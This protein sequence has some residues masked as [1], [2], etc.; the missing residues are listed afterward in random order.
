[1]N[2]LGKSKTD[3]N[4]NLSKLTAKNLE[5]ARRTVQATQFRSFAQKASFDATAQLGRMVQLVTKKD[6]FKKR[7]EN[8]T[9]SNTRKPPNG[10]KS[11]IISENMP[12][13][14]IRS[15]KDVELSRNAAEET[16]M[17]GKVTNGS[18]HARFNIYKKGSLKKLM[19]SSNSTLYKSYEPNP[20][21]SMK[22]LSQLTSRKLEAK[23]TQVPIVGNI[24]QGN[25][26]PRSKRK[27]F[28]SMI[29]QP[30]KQSSKLID[31][32]ELSA[33]KE[34][35][36]EV[37]E[38]D[39]VLRPGTL[40]NKTVSGA[41]MKS[42]EH[43]STSRNLLGKES[44]HNRSPSKNSSPVSAQN[45]N[46]FR[47]VIMKNTGKVAISLARI[48]ASLGQHAC[49]IGEAKEPTR[50]GAWNGKKLLDHGYEA[51]DINR[52]KKMMVSVDRLKDRVEVVGYSTYRNRSN[53]TF[54]DVL[55]PRARLVTNRQ[56]DNPRS[57]SNQAS[58]N[59]ETNRSLSKTG[60][61]DLKLPL[62]TNMKKFIQEKIRNDDNFSLI[63][64]LIANEREK[65]INLAKLHTYLGG[66][67]KEILLTNLIVKGSHFN[68]PLEK[69]ERVTLD[70]P[71]RDKTKLKTILI[72]LDETLVHA[73]PIKPGE[74]Y[75]HTFDLTR[76]PI[77]LR[78]RPY[79]SYF[80]EE[81][82][83]KFELVLYTASGEIY[84][85]KIRQIID[86]HS[87]HF[88]AALHRKNCVY[89]K[90]A[91]LKSIDAITNRNRADML[92]IDNALYAFPFDHAHKLLIRPFF[93]DKEDCELLKMLIFIRES[94]IDKKK[95]FA[96]GLAEKMGCKDLM[97]C[98]QIGDL[99]GLF[100]RHMKQGVVII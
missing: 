40:F 66:L 24:R 22:P 45:R 27:N 30:G 56:Y 71:A 37:E 19:E 61:R 88:S 68:N 47:S 96:N 36:T 1:M 55:A 87:V 14:S 93:N 48:D 58:N 31:I 92:I 51:K 78:I 75:D 57:V 90:T 35:N 20:F 97:G 81:L 7:V 16:N 9:S 18:R 41:L 28:A 32:R 34:R 86:P 12:I 79:L 26:I 3:L 60:K 89:F 67:Y 42:K 46:Q 73:E 29:V 43:K 53:N 80:L 25:I 94:F 44:F 10:L 65:K 54:K 50:S 98:T 11:S 76:G 4:L 100:K 33:S 70:K 23:A 38:R 82:N 15:K 64:I 95:D 69:L 72:D 2:G 52:F 8:L 39:S 49:G 77:G 85:N 84:A 83:K 17:D 62:W 99:V 13:E 21:T 63:D 59:D 6:N 91:H 5:L 74:V